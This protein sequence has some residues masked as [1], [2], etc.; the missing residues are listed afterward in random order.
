MY[1]N[2]FTFE[3]FKIQPP[4]KL[5]VMYSKVVE[6]DEPYLFTVDHFQIHLIV[7]EQN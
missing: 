7:F 1:R 6:L 5:K 3:F 4:L 2:K